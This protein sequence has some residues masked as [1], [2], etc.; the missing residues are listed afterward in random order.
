ENPF[1]H[2]GGLLPIGTPFPGDFDSNSYFITQG[3]SSIEMNVV[4]K[5]KRV[6]RKGFF[7][8]FGLFEDNLKSEI[9]T[10]GNTYATQ[11]QEISYLDVVLIKNF[12]EEAEIP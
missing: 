7:G 8:F 3:D 11:R 2:S 4:S 9:T 6:I 12:L 5:S 1:A 10:T